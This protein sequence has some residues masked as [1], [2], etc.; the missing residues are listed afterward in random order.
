MLHLPFSF[1]SLLIATFLLVALPPT[2]ALVQMWWHL[3]QLS[4]GAESRLADVDRWQ[5]SLHRLSERQEHLERSTRQWLV[6][7]DPFFQQLA[8]GFAQDMLVSVDSLSVVPDRVFAQQLASEKR[9]IQLLA[10]KLARSRDLSSAEITPLFDQLSGCLQSM[11]QRLQL[12]SLTQQKNWAESLKIQR[13]QADRLALFSLLFALLL[14]LLLAYLLFAPLGRLRYKIGRLAQGRRG[15][16]WRVGGPTDV[17]NLADALQRLDAR[18]EQLE[19]EKASF[20]RQVSHELKTPLAAIHEAAALL[21]DE[22]PGSLTPAQREI[23][24]IQLSNTATLR[25][26]VDTLLKHD[27]ARWLGQQVE[28]RECSLAQLLQQRLHDWQTLIARRN[29]QLEMQLQVDHVRG[30]EQKVQTILDNLLINAMRFSPA[31][32]IITLRSQRHDA[33]I[34]LQVIDHGPGVALQ[35]AEHIF[36][37]FFSGRAPVGESAGSGIGLTMARTFAQL[38]GGDVRLQEAGVRGACFELWWPE[39]GHDPDDKNS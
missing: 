5:N 15:Q 37:P 19:T 32:G 26:R 6:L 18:L 38:M 23:V 35:D 8:V 14:A 10:G 24:A 9:Q 17:R 3:D 21:V 33:G 25:Q 7:S 28:F 13:L 29:L 30:D 39:S 34:L 4:L 2:V 22:V 1:R 16:V 27:V 11:T 20:F 31:D 36:E 12:M